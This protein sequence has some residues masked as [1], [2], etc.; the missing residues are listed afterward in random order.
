[1]TV[2]RV[3]PRDGNVASQAAEIHRDVIH[4]GFLSTLGQ[5]FLEILYRTL[6]GSENAFVAGEI[7]VPTPGPEE[8]KPV[9][10]T[11]ASGLLGSD[12]KPASSDPDTGSRTPPL[13]RRS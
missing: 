2:L 13:E 5:D 12:N 11:A 8:K 1:M 9:E 10:F 7:D 6:S 3:T 4:E